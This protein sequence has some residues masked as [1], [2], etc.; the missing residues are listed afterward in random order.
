MSFI[1][2]LNESE[3]LAQEFQRDPP[4]VLS[5]DAKRNRTTLHEIKKI[6]NYYKVNKPLLS[7]ARR[8]MIEEKLELEK[9]AL[10]KA[11]ERTKAEDLMARY[12]FNPFTEKENMRM[13]RTLSQ[14]AMKD[15]LSKGK[16]QPMHE[17]FQ[18]R[19]IVDA[20]HS[21]SS[22]KFP[23][24]TDEFYDIRKGAE[25]QSSAFLQHAKKSYLNQS[26]Q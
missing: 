8:D 25:K 14:K 3:L 24:Q 2:P 19:N 12:H 22:K 16:K 17:T 4:A 11:K 18:P 21:I 23:K 5:N 20:I 9:I 10:Q 26:K 7:K 15:A 13:N 6:E 1:Q